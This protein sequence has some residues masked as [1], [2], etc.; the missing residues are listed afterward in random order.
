M[1][2]SLV[3]GLGAGFPGHIIDHVV[4][5]TTSD[6]RNFLPHGSA[7]VASAPM[8]SRWSGRNTGNQKSPQ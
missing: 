1:F 3:G 8:H 2:A 7:P 5:G 4:V 6:R